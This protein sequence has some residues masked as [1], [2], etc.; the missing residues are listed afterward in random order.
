[1]DIN[2]IK[3]ASKTTLFRAEFKDF[4]NDVYRYLNS[5]FNIDEKQQILDIAFDEWTKKRNESRSKISI[6]DLLEKEGLEKGFR[7]IPS[8]C[9]GR[10]CHCCHFSATHQEYVNEC[11]GYLCFCSKHG[12]GCIQRMSRQ[13]MQELEIIQKAKE[14]PALLWTEEKKLKQRF[15]CPKC[16]EETGRH[17]E[18]IRGTNICPKHGSI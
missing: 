7:I 3:Y 14:R 1:M 13:R 17:V 9:Q 6:T 15:Y 5:P 12:A 8:E 16:Y 18:I 2:R 11:Q 4:L 10:K